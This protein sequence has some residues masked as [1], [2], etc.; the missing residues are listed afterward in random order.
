MWT[1]ERRPL[2]F[3]L[4]LA[5]TMIAFESLGVA[6][7]MPETARDLDGLALYGW[8]FSASTLAALVGISI[9]GPQ[10]DRFGPARPFAAGLVLF[11][12]GL[13]IAGLAP[14]MPIVV[15]GRLVQGLGIGLVP[16]VV[17]ASIGRAYGDAGRARMFALLSTA[18]VLPGLIGPAISGIVAESLGWRWV[19]LGLLPLVPL[20]AALTL[21]ALARLPA[22]EDA[23]DVIGGRVPHALRLAAG[24]GLIIGGLGNR[25]WAAIPLV[26]LGGL[27]AVPALRRLLPEGSLRAAA[28]LPAAV[29]TRGL[30]T[31]AFFG[32]EAF[33]PLTITR[34]RGQ[35]SV[36][37]GITLTVAALSWTTGAWI[38]DRRG[39]RLGRG[40]LVRR[41]MV[42]V[43]VGVGGLLLVLIPAVPVWVAAVSWAVAGFGMGIAYGGISLIALA[44]AP[45]GREG[46]AAS[47]VSLADVLGVSLST[48]AGGALV[49]AGEAFDWSPRVGVGGAFALATVGGCLGVIATRRIPR[50]V[51]TEPQVV[52]AA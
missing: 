48:G 20:N 14:S 39:A 30:E 29:A 19:F 2:T 4:L 50:H 41:G 15:V 18:W 8:A 33:L 42:L 27:L 23:H 5:I 13:T 11:A 17:Y 6:T 47:A 38:Q 51:P 43:T 22:V 34:V 35:S 16:P 32:A 49:A 28:G 21:P 9:A 46:S 1:K 12:A 10:A 44:L 24:T 37:G 52:P 3:G 7:A 45:S 31:F 36:V 26:L 25:S 40:T